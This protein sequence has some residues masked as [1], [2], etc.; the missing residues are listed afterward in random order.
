MQGTF[1]PPPL[2]ADGTS[3]SVLTTTWSNSTCFSQKYAKIP[4]NIV[5]TSPI[6]CEKVMFSHALVWLVAIVISR[7]CRKWAWSHVCACAISIRVYGA[8]PPLNGPA[9][10]P[11]YVRTYIRHDH[12]YKRD[13]G[14][15]KC[16]CAMHDRSTK[17]VTSL[18][19]HRTSLVQTVSSTSLE[20][21]L[22]IQTACS[23]TNLLRILVMSQSTKTSFVS[24]QNVECQSCRLML[25]C[26]TLI[27]CLK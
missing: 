4:A 15:S 6:S 23:A 2:Q 22:A 17:R 3:S 20:P 14:Q 16:A 18:E 7:R 25:C 24:I 1:P 13:K 5:A 9:S 21:G 8:L 10:A 27:I 19:W 12:Y 11:A 26:S